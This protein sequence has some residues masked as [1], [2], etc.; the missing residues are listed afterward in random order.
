MFDALSGLQWWIETP[1]VCVC[2]LGMMGPLSFP[3]CVGA[4]PHRAADAARSRRRGD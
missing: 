3:N 4:R 2:G 1:Q